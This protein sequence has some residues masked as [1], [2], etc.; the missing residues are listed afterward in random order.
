MKEKKASPLAAIT[1][2]NMCMLG[3]LHSM[4][5]VSFPLIKNNFNA[6]YND[7]GILNALVSFFAVCFCIIAGSYMS[8]FGIKK[9]II[10]AF[11]LVIAGAISIYFTVSFWMA[12]GF[13]L[14]LQSG[15][16]FFEISINGTGVR[17][18]TKKSGLMLNLLHFFYGM[19]AIIGPWF[20]SLVITRIGLSW[21][22]TY[23]LVLLPIAVLLIITLI[24]RYPD[25][26]EVR[27]KK[28]KLLFWTALKDP[29]VWFFGIILGIAGSIEGCTVAWGGLFLQDVYGYDVSTAGAAFVSTFYVLYTVS[30]LL[31]GFIIE[32][33]GLIKSIFLS[34]LLITILFLTAFI[35]GRTGIIL[36]PVVGFFLAIMWPTVLAISVGVFKEKAQ[37]I[38]SALICIAFTLGGIIQYGF[39]LSNRFLGAAWGYR[40]CV[41]YSLILIFL[42]FMLGKLNKKKAWKIQ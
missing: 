33:I 9:T 3:F 24:I 41:L 20:M 40:S 28:E 34:S 6:S 37:T 39:G 18:F 25:N 14:V 17:I 22:G 29:M 23:P 2:G 8:R 15:F 19:G 12:A 1:F 26:P 4:R 13:Y 31:S 32:R 36:L 42:L 7:M 35:L 21:Q 11:F 38:S 5:G 16:S 27:E 30:R 10:T